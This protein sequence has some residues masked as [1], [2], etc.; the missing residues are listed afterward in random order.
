MEL[1]KGAPVSAAI[2]AQVNSE[3]AELEGRDITPRLAVVRIGESADDIAYENAAAKRCESVGVDVKRVTLPETAT[4]EAV[5]AVI[6]WLNGDHSIHGV[7][8]LRPMPKHLDEHAICE[9]LS[10]AKDVDGVTALSLAG[11]FTNRALGFPP[12]TA[13]ACVEIL[14][15]YGYDVA[16]K[17]TVVVGRSLVVG[18]PVAMLLLNRHATV[19]M[20]HTRTKNLRDIC[21]GAELLVVAAGTAGVVNE[22]FI[23]EGQV[24][25][26]VGIH[27]GEDGK[28]YGDVLCGKTPPAEAITPVPGGVGSV[29][30]AVLVSHV[31]QAAKRAQTSYEP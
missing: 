10:T 24:V 26:D 7:L 27:V 31:V 28:M 3:V 1:L 16:G 12:C 25:V 18:K 20:C 14:S 30:T 2:M 29:T 4:Q 23:S 11:V 8:L 6:D 5:V 17:R 19:T 22:T 13:Q 15:Y 9:R 21:H